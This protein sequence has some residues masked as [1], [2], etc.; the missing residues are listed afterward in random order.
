MRGKQ[1]EELE[2]RNDA[3]VTNFIKSNYNNVLG[4]GIFMILTSS[5]RQ[6]ILNPQIE[7]IISQAPPY[8][9]SNQY[10]QEYIK[11][12]EKNMEKLREY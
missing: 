2:A 11:A 10:V 4:P 9:L 3:L 1:M 5:F 12:A 7:A 6:P 8:F